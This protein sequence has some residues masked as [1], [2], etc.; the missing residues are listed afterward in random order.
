[1]WFSSDYWYSFHY[2]DSRGYVIFCCHG[3]AS[4]L[5]TICTL[6]SDYNIQWILHQSVL[7]LIIVTHDPNLFERN[8]FFDFIV[9]LIVISQKSS[10][11]SL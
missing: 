3:V 2:S 4:N 9:H 6:Q 10:I 1:M 11:I 7:L 5:R 8:Q